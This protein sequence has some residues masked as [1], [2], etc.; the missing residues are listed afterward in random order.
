MLKMGSTGE[1]V[2]LLQQLLRHDGEGLSIDGVFGPRTERAV[3]HA[4]RKHG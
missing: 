3:R 4:Q 2:R 1:E